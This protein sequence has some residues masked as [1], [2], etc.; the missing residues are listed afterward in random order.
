MPDFAKSSMRATTARNH[1][2]LCCSSRSAFD[3]NA[4]E[5]RHHGETD[6]AALMLGVP[7]GS[8]TAH[9]VQFRAIRVNQVSDQ[10]VDEIGET[11]NEFRGLAAFPSRN[12]QSGHGSLPCP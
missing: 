7:L 3:A 11:S 2:G 6:G 4:H 10:P 12:R 1:A 8:R 9:V 5:L